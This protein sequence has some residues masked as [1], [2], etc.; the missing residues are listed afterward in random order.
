MF[1]PVIPNPSKTWLSGIICSCATS[2]LC[3]SNDGTAGMKS[4]GS[5]GRSVMTYLLIEA[6]GLRRSNVIGWAAG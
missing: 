1:P 4:W 3:T 5:G 6:D 2:S